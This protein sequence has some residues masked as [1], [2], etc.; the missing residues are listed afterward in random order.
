M[1]ASVRI[2][3][4]SMSF[5]WLMNYRLRLLNS[6]NDGFSVCIGISQVVVVAEIVFAMELFKLEI[7]T[8]DQATLQI[9]V[10]A[11]ESKVRLTKIIAI[12]SMGL[13]AAELVVRAIIRDYFIG[14]IIFVSE[15]FLV[16]SFML[17]YTMKFSK[18]VN[19][20]Q[21][22]LGVDF[23]DEKNQLRCSLGVFLCTYFLRSVIKGLTLAL[24]K[25]YGTLWSEPIFAESL[26]CL[27][28]FVYDVWPLLTIAHQHH[29]AF[30]EQTRVTKSTIQTVD[31]GTTEYT[32]LRGF[33]DQS[34][35]TS[36]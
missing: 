14:N 23:M 15:L 5:N 25:V 21:K 26:V 1:L 16:A 8:M 17:Y 4:H 7:D 31:E 24:Q 9:N 11:K 29:S 18:L 13:T 10:D 27:V 12:L 33:N 34:M 20:V 3:Q 32:Q 6:L 22:T 28:Q 2:I 19:E 35:V 36:Q 30:K